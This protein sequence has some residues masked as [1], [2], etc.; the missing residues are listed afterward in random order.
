MELQTYYNLCN[1]INFS[2][3]ISVPSNQKPLVNASLI[4]KEKMFNTNNNNA[5]SIINI[6]NQH[7]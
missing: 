6:T 5:S 7:V 2:N 1:S 3:D 4:V